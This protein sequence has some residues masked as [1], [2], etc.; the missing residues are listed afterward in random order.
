[1]M[2]DLNFDPMDHHGSDDAPGVP[3][4]SAEC[5]VPGDAAPPEPPASPYRVRCANG[6]DMPLVF[7]SWAKSFKL[8]RPRE[9]PAVG[10]VSADSFM[11]L[12]DRRMLAPN[13]WREALN[14][15]IERLAEKCGIAVAFHPADPSVVV[16]WIAF[17]VGEDATTIHYLW[18]RADFR[19][20]GVARL[21]LDTVLGISERSTVRASF[22]TADGQHMLRR[23]R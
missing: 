20:Q 10:P 21:L 2:E 14:W 1:M 5:G 22:M 23:Y 6:E 18:T 19:R 16:G 17:D 8:P 12:A 3:E 9:M 13:L 15:T 11:V 4:P 7:D